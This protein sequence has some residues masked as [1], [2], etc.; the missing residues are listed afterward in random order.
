M[1]DPGNHLLVRIFAYRNVREDGNPIDVEAGDTA[2]SSTSVAI[3]GA[4]TTGPNRTV[5]AAVADATDA[6]GA[7]LSAAANANLVGTAEQ[8]DFGTIQGT[9]GGIGV[10]T[11]IKRVAGA[12][13]NTTAT[14][15]TASAQARHSVALRPRE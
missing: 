7:R 15:S 12:Y 13:G 5:V 14:L 2:A 11:G 4:T 3:P 10:I 8:A 6:T 1:L 9:G